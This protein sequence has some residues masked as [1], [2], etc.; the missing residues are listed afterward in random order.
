MTQMELTAV[1]QRTLDSLIGSGERPVFS[2]DLSVRL[3]DKI[4]EAVR[5]L[6]LAGS[7]W[8]SKEKL[9]DAGRCDGLFAAAMLGEKPPFE[10]SRRSAAGKLVHKSVELDVASQQEIASHELAVRAAERLM[11]DRSFEAFWRALDGLTQDEILMEATKSLELFRATFPPL[12]MLRRQLAPVPEAWMKAELLG[13]SL[14]LSGQIDLLLGAADTQPGRGTRLAID[15]KDTRRGWPEYP[16][17]MRFYAL[18]MTLRFGVPPYRVATLFLE[19]GEWQP[20][21]VTEE[22]LQHAADR[23]IAAVRAH[24][25]LAAGRAPELRPGAYCGWCPRSA[26]CPAKAVFEETGIAQPGG[27]EYR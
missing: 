18:L 5:G 15:L 11:E 2:A 26:T 3:R 7:V 24:R 6:E 17:D 21:D 25:S 16:E 9:N 12:R 22:V 8:L 20:E 14:V 13:G 27:V 1:Q 10:H 23:V 4:E 19:S